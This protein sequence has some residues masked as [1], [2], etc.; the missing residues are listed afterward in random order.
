[1][2]LTSKGSGTEIAGVAVPCVDAEHMVGAVDVCR[3]EPIG[4]H[5]RVIVSGQNLAGL[6]TMAV[7]WAEWTRM[8]LIRGG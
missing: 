4:S 5:R 7:L 1:M 6:P 2:I 3:R 8:V